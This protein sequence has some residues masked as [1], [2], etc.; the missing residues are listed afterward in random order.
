MEDARVCN[1][2]E[3]SVLVDGSRNSGNLS[4][5]K[6]LGSGSL[7]QIVLKPR[8]WTRLP[9]A[10]DTHDF[11]MGLAYQDHEELSLT[12]KIYP[13]TKRTRTFVHTWFLTSYHAVGG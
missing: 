13:P 12:G 9:P 10:D 6:S 1:M 3:T 5:Q 4:F 2:S 7:A 11:L 8:F